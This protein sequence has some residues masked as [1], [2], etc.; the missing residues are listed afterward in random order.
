MTNLRSVTIN[1]VHYMYSSFG[2]LED[3][4]MTYFSKKAESDS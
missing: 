4:G 3:S 1:S 2:T